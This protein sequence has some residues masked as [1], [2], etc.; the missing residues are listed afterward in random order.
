MSSI[1]EY[2][3]YKESVV[4]GAVKNRESCGSEGIYLCF[5]QVDI[6]LISIT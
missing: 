5:L 2:E 3:K 6:N 4:V 1:Q